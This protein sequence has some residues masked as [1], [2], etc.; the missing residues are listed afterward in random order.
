VYPIRR[1]NSWIELTID[2]GTIVAGR[3]SSPICELELELKRGAAAELFNVARALAMWAPVQLSVTSKPERGYALVTGEKSRAVGAAPI[4]ILPD[5]NCQAVFQAIARACLRQI[6]VNQTLARDGDSEG[7]HQTRVGLRRL[8]AAISLFG[9]MLPDPQSGTVKRELKWITRELGPARELD[10]FIKK[11]MPAIA[12]KSHQPGI[13]TLTRDL[14]RR[15]REA[16]NRSRAAIAS[17]RFRALI[18]DSAAW[19]ET[20]DWTNNADDLVRALRDQPIATAAVGEMNRRRKKILKRGA[21][22]IDLDPLHRH[23]I[24]IE[25]KKLR[26]AC[27]FLGGIF[28]GK[29]TA[30]QRKELLSALEQ[31]QDTLGDLNDISVHE[32]LTEQLAIVLEDSGRRKQHSPNKAFAA[33]RLF[34][35]EEARIASVL[36]DAVRAYARFAKTKPFWW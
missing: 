35:R 29:K 4:A 3:Q 30:R 19:I 13:A 26:Y 5:E 10:V 8:R 32:R 31:L 14:R 22:L 36:Q 1:H 23:R 17:E 27:Q 6:I 7:L 11:V 16:L 15:R 20:G 2:K 24:R 33:G 18:L 21:R 9:S 34:G 28:F 12:G 25:A